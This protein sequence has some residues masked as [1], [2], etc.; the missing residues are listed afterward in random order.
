MKTFS[1]SERL[2]GKVSIDELMANGK[3]FNNFP[4]RVTWAETS[5]PKE[6][7]KM[8]IS[9]PKRLF[10]KAI[11]RNRLKRLIREGYRHNKHIL[12]DRL[13]SKKINFLIVYT[14]KKIIDSKELNER[15]VGILQ[16]LADKIG[17]Q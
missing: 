2:C 10:K 9:V 7:A 8:M 5:R 6:P 11:E 16:Q 14:S 17:V 4:F 1:K 13:N 15:M 3:S 12:I